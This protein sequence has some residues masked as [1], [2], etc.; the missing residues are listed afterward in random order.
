MAR[1]HSRRGN[2]L[3]DGLP[4]LVAARHPLEEAFLQLVG[5]ETVE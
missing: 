3:F 5:E 4:A 1:E 2:V